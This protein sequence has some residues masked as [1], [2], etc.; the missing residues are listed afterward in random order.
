MLTK[1]NWYHKEVIEIL[2]SY[3]KFVAEEILLRLSSDKRMEHYWNSRKMKKK[4]KMEL[5]RQVVHFLAL[6]RTQVP[7]A[8]MLAKANAC[9]SVMPRTRETRKR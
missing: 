1:K 5:F 4:Q 3:K 6:G 8:D 9:L 7:H 2:E